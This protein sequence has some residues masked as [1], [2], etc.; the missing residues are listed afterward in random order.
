VPADA[1]SW[2]TLALDPRE[3]SLVRRRALGMA[4]RLEPGSSSVRDVVA[5]LAQAPG[6]TS[7]VRS[8]ALRTLARIAP[9]AAR[10]VARPL[11]AEGDP[12]LA[13]AARRALGR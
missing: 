2:L 1:G 10:D 12:L 3:P 9:Q 4:A 11:A 5:A 7:V 13:G 6:E 8:G